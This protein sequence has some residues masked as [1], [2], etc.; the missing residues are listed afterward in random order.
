MKRLFKKRQKIGKGMPSAVLLSIVIHAALFLLAGMLVVFTVVKKEEKKFVPPKAVERPK[1]K[2]RKPKV[3]VKKTSKPKP[4]TR[5]VTKV[6]RANMPDIQLPEMSGMGG[7]GLGAGVG[8]F[9]MMPDLGDI[10]VFGSGQSIG[11]DFVGTFYDFQ[12]DRS[13]RDIP[14]APEAF[15]QKLVKFVGSGWQASKIGR[16]YQSP[17]KLFATCFMVPPIRSTVAPA[18]FGEPDTGGYC[19]MVHY[20][21]QLVHSKGITF[22]FWGQG[23]DLLVVRV[24]GKVVLIANWSGKWD[25]MAEEYFMQIW[26]PSS[27]DSRKYYM[28][29]NRSVVGD[30]ITLEPGVSLDMEVMIGEVGG[31]SY[32]SML[33]VEVEGVEYEKGPQGNPIL[34][35][36]KTA[37]L[38]HD[39]IDAIYKDL[40]PGEICVTNGPVFCDYDTSGWE[41]TKES[42][43]AGLPEPV[44]SVENEPRTW[45][46]M[47]GKT[48]EAELVTVIGQK[49]VLKSEDGR[50]RKIPLL[51]LSDEDREIIE[52]A[53]PPKFNMDFSKK[54]S[55]TIGK[56][57]P[58]NT[59]PPPKVLDYVFSAKLKQTSA[60]RY[61]HELHVEFYAIGS[62]ITGDHYVLL[63]R[64]ES[65]FTPT[66]ENERSHVFSGK[67]VRLTSYELDG[68]N[69]GIK[70]ESS[71]IVVT[72]SRGVVI[73]HRTSND[74][75][76]ENRG[77]LRRLSVGSY[78]DET[79]TRVFPSRPKTNIY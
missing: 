63:D 58:F 37:S 30:W 38:T 1:M 27:A 40:V 60:G 12:R 32:C 72:D 76:F 8:G 57:S 65:R 23:D 54:S 39:L 9:D 74:W 64:Q 34:P 55:Q 42:A 31:G 62:E 43:G 16:Y 35:M 41:G 44:L 6:N 50:Q 59:Q 77:N 78:M 71:L 7:E 4:T 56:M 45:T 66:R 75:L 70:Y 47:D 67:P 26:S 11:N 49:A 21:G 10:S 14:V 19:W 51:Q 48:M 20:K 15:L 3:K 69:R 61:N 52:L 68:I 53:R 33:A 29:N 22:R 2:L 25:Q 28:G 46:R 36:F 79:C 13:G 73:D 5:I 18:A 24:G 17:K